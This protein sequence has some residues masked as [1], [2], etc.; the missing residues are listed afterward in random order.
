VV[1]AGAPTTGYF[2]ATLRVANRT[3]LTAFQI[4]VAYF[5]PGGLRWRFDHGYFLATLRVAKPD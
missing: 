3:L 4:N 1:C 2:L 5:A